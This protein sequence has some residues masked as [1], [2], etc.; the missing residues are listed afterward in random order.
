MISKIYNVF[1][2]WTGLQ[3]VLIG[4]K[5]K[6]KVARGEKVKLVF[7]CQLPHVW[8]C[9]ESVYEEAIKDKVFDVY[10][11]AVPNK[12]ENAEVDSDAYDFCKAHG[13]K[14]IDAY[15]REKKEFFDLK[16]L[17]PDYVFFPRPYDYYLPKQYTSIEVSKYAKPSYVSYCY[18]AEGGEILETCYDKYFTSFCYFVFPDNDSTEQ[19]CKNNH[20]LSLLLGTKKIIRT[21]YPRFDLMKRWEGCEPEHWKIKKESVKKRIIWTP[22]WA[23]DKRMG[24]T[25]FFEYK[26]FFLKFAEEHKDCDFMF[27][28]HPL[29]FQHFIDTGHMTEEEVQAYKKICEAGSNTQIDERSEYLDSFA[30][31]DILVSDMSG[32]MEDFLVTGSPLVFC[33]FEQE[34]NEANK[35]LLDA[36]YISH[37]KDEMR[38]ILEML[39]AGNDPKKEQRKEIVRNV[40]GECDGKNGKRILDYIRADIGVL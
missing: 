37:N 31:A 34:V 19:Y 1:R 11:L 18:V 16:K 32:V 4:N 24:A 29:A 7:I 14:V 9:I 15:D 22:R 26:E 39:I 25:T 33:S 5:T 10:I 35:K 2:R 27:R 30:S 6:K 17:E 36:F 12:F 23:T 21:P 3:Y 8:S 13:Y 38:E 28:P 40:L 20:R